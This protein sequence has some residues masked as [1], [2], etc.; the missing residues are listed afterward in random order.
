MSRVELLA[1]QDC[2]LIEGRGVVVIPDFSVPN[3]WKD[4]AETV[5]VTKPD[6]QMYEAAAQ[7]S[8]SHFR[9]LDRT[10]S[11]D[12]SWRIIVLLLDRKKDDLP[13]GSKIAV[14]QETRDAILPHNVV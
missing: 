4:R 10:A 13:V 5:A 1:V 6:G 12:R 2:F 3:G 14:S 8:M 9:L 7:F 11:L